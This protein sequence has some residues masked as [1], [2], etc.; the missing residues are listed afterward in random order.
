MQVV[1][2][3]LEIRLPPKFGYPL[4]EPTTH[5][6]AHSRGLASISKQV[7]LY[8]KL[9]RVAQGQVVHLC[10]GPSL[11]HLLPPR[12]T[13]PQ[14]G[15]SH[16]CL[17]SAPHG[18]SQRWGGQKRGVQLCWDSE[19]LGCPLMGMWMVAA[20]PSHLAQGGRALPLSPSNHERQEQCAS[21]S[22][23]FAPVASLQAPRDSSA[24]IA[25]FLKGH[26]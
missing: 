6:P 7:S 26:L 10:S 1:E 16:L 3:F 19:G 5:P 17:A 13:A 18:N 4:P 21:G 24:G 11:A 23:W 2:G 14:K 20:S 25:V 9:H 15:P 12:H 8:S 22:D